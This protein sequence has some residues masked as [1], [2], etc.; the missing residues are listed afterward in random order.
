MRIQKINTKIKVVNTSKFIGSVKNDTLYIRDTMSNIRAVYCTKCFDND[1]FENGIVYNL[2][3]NFVDAIKSDDVT[4]SNECFVADG[5]SRRM[6]ISV[7]NYEVDDVI[8]KPEEEC[9]YYE[10]QIPYFYKSAFKRSKQDF[11]T[12]E[13]LCGIHHGYMT[14]TD[15]CFAVVQKVDIPVLAIPYCVGEAISKFDSTHKIKAFCKKDSRVLIEVI[16][17]NNS[18]VA[19]F[20]YQFKDRDLNMDGIIPHTQREN[21]IVIKR[22]DFGALKK[23]LKNKYEDAIFI[24]A[25]IVAC[26][27]GSVTIS[28]S[29]PPKSDPVVV[30]NYIILNL[31]NICEDAGC[32]MV[33][34][35]NNGHDRMMKSEL[36]DEVMFITMRQDIKKKEA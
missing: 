18:L 32:D 7:S 29:M 11:N 3:N 27:S 9:E 36:P 34:G 35:Y 12:N 22:K 23:L 19:Q 10:V 4:I 15:L 24:A 31:I 30:K 33:L 21:N 14:V 13:F 17:S 25:N 28:L 8:F 1:I 26:N 5:I 6:N 2:Q 16:D 20:S